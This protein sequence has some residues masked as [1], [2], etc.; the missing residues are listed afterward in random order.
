MEVIFIWKYGS[1]FCNASNKLLLKLQTCQNRALRIC[2]GVP[3]GTAASAVEKV[4]LCPN[5]LIRLDNLAKRTYLNQLILYKSCRVTSNPLPTQIKVSMTPITDISPCS[6]IPVIKFLK[7][8]NSSVL[9]R[10]HI[11]WLSPTYHFHN[12]LFDYSL[13]PK[14]DLTGVAVKSVAESFQGLIESKYKDYIHVYTDG[15]FVPSISCAAAVYI[16]TRGFSRIVPLSVHSNSLFRNFL[17][18][19]WLSYF[20][21]RTLR[22]LTRQF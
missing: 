8:N 9:I 5:L 6:L 22:L 12:V 1:K 4:T 13:L 10:D 15:S 19:S 20:W 7:D 18:C 21:F 3:L 2:A 17:L 11:S 14:K 16:P